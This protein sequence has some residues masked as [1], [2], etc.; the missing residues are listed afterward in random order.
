MERVTN[1]MSP[2]SLA[3]E[4]GDISLAERGRI[5]VAMMG[6]LRAVQEAIVDGGTPFIWLWADG[7]GSLMLDPPKGAPEHLTSWDSLAQAPDVLR[8][9]SESED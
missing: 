9:F 2:N 6:Y 8:Y 3:G 1:D 5:L 7:S 4:T